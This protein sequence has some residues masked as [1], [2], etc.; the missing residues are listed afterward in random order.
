MMIGL[1]YNAFE[2]FWKQN[3]ALLYGLAI[4]LGIVIALNSFSYF[5]II[6]I[7]FIA[8][9]IFGLGKYNSLRLLLAALVFIGG[10]ALV[11][12][13]YQFPEKLPEKGLTG[14]AFIDI[15][16]LSLKK[17]SFGTRWIYRGT[18]RAFYPDNS[19]QKAYVKNIPYTLSVPAK[20]GVQ[21]PIAN[22]SY[23]VHATLRQSPS[24]YYSLKVSS[25]DAW[26]PV[27][28]TWSLAEYR[29]L[30]KNHV[31][32][33]IKRSIKNERSAAFL[34][35][36][37]TGEF[38]DMIMSFEF[39]RF[40]LQHIMAISG[41]HFAIV[42][43]ILSVIFRIFLPRKIAYTALM[44]ILSSYFVF[45]GCGPSIMRAWITIMIA[46]MGMLIG[47]RTYALNSMG[48]SMLVI[49]L[50]DPLMC[51]HIGFQF[52]FL[53]T[54]AILCFFSGA[55]YLT[56]NIFEKRSLSIAIRMHSLDQHL[57]FLLA[58]FKNA[59]ALGLAVN[60]IALP[61]SLFYFHKFPILS[62]LYNLFFPFMVSISMLL[63]ILAALF[64][65][66]PYIGQFLHA[67][68]SAYTEYM[69]NLTYNLP[70]SW[71]ITWRV[72]DFPN[73]VIII[74]LCIVFSAGIVCRYLI[75]Q[76]RQSD[77]DFNFI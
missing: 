55:Q 30:S 46:L 41:F 27:K 26:Y 72:S 73:V 76:K 42:A 13:S 11:K 10:F 6:S 47:K 23:R 29:Y 24:G 36:I 57:Y 50:F 53:T 35:G 58:S 1:V 52:S 65:I 38:D 69:L 8:L 43:V 20:A 74:Y 49:L 66:F 62:L 44:L 2:K 60:I 34:A 77:Q 25:D 17:S 64:S 68:N 18:L 67:L 75:Q 22:Q 14:H 3:P 19:L 12:T 54:A 37:A 31:A 59:L 70:A 48:F 21:R 32:H 61:V 39:S 9:P 71:D 16:S 63:L 45:L 15:S 51:L 5:F 33:Y 40:G 56:E 4:L 28:N 7:L